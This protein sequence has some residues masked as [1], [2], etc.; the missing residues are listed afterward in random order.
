MMFQRSIARLQPATALW[1]QGWNVADR[2]KLKCHLS[3]CQPVR[4]ATLAPTAS[5]RPDRLGRVARAGRGRVMA[6]PLRL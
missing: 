3:L 4:N 6:P 2:A 5:P 1:R